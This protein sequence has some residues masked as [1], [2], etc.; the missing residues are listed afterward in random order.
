MGMIMVR[1]RHRVSSF[2]MI[3]LFL[4]AVAIKKQKLTSCNHYYLL[5]FTFF[6]GIHSGR[7][8]RKRQ[9]KVATFA[10]FPSSAIVDATA[11]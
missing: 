8:D 10:S 4:F 1:Q 5:C 9:G 2:I 7:T 3:V 11:Y 6:F